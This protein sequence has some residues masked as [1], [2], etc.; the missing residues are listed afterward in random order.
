MSIARAEAELRELQ[1]K[2]ELYQSLI[3]NAQARAADLRTYI[4]IAAELGDGG[5]DRSAEA[6]GDRAASREAGATS[7]ESRRGDDANKAARARALSVEAVTNKGEAMLTR[8]LVD[9]LAA[10]GLT[11]GRGNPKRATGDLSGIL[12]R[13]PLLENPGRSVGWVLKAWDGAHSAAE[14]ERRRQ[15]AANLFAAPGREAG[16]DTEGTIPDAADGQLGNR[17]PKTSEPEPDKIPRQ[18]AE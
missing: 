12:G 10:R 16:D 7:G 6:A 17:E 11:F 2:I 14:A 8:D 5:V 15:A 18:A 13:E 3:I 9:L 1:E 4:R